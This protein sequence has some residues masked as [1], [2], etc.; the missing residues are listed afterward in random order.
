M[1]LYIKDGLR[2]VK[3]GGMLI[4]GINRFG[5]MYIRFNLILLEKFEDMNIVLLILEK[6]FLILFNNKL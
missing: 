5:D 2:K 4:V 1:L 6:M 3:G